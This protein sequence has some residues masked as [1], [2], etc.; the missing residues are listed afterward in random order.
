M[1]KKHPLYKKALSLTHRLC[2]LSVGIVLWFVLLTAILLASRPYL[3]ANLSFDDTKLEER[4]FNSIFEKKEG[5]DQISKEDYLALP[6]EKRTDWKL[7]E[8]T[9]FLYSGLFC[10][11]FLRYD[12]SAVLQKGIRFSFGSA[13]D[14]HDYAPVMTAALL[15]AGLIAV[16]YVVLTLCIRA[17][18]TGVKAVPKCQLG[19]QKNNKRTDKEPLS[20]AER[21][22][23]RRW[24][25][26]AATLLA[27]VLLAGNLLGL[28]ALQGNW[29][30]E[31]IDKALVDGTSFSKNGREEGTHLVFFCFDLQF[32]QDTLAFHPK[33]IVHLWT[34]NGERVELDDLPL[35]L[36]AQLAW[37]SGFHMESYRRTSF[38]PESLLKIP[39]LYLLPAVLIIGAFLWLLLFKKE[40]ALRKRGG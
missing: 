6:A 40:R 28:A 22:C 19:E 5:G 32:V 26:L 27:V 18:L 3:I 33:L 16:L 1:K 7:K 11:F 39:S 12:A 30:V 24:T 2:S 25:V 8:G 38:S 21:L 35:R 37:G 29:Q 23:K 36:G 9:V 34:P 13:N 31:G 15:L 14:L 10:D 4:T 17:A 20:P